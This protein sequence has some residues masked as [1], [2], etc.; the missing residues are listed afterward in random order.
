MTQKKATRPVFLPDPDS[1]NLIE[2]RSL[3]F[4]W[5][6]GLAPSQ[7][8][9]SVTELHAEAIKAIGLHREGI[10]EVSRRSTSPLGERL[11][12]F[13]LSFK[14]RKKQLTY[15]V[16]S[17]YQASKV[18][19]KG[20]PHPDIMTMSGR[21]AKTDTRLKT[22]GDLSHFE[23]F[24]Q[25]W[26]LKPAGAF[27]TW[28]YINALRQHPQI[29]ADLMRY[30]AFTDIEFNPK[31]SFSCQALAVA[32]FVS[33]SIKGEVDAALSS[34]DQFLEMMRKV[35]SPYTGSQSKLQTSIEL[36]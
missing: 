25:R 23:F 4:P 14:T 33:L 35:P 34:K 16:E 28:I 9:K 22:S 32:L 31:T 20:G 1:D 12:A 26:E 29:G 17:A 24:G 19:E 2:I 30:A 5:H 8:E 3:E 21:G 7:K 11:S 27:Y 36:T 15:C 10:L 6:A 18:F 13:N